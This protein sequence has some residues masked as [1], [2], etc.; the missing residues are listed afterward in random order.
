MIG[1]RE[2]FPFFFIKLLIVMLIYP[3]LS[4]GSYRSYFNMRESVF[5]DITPFPKWTGMIERYSAQLEMPDSKCGTVIYYPCTV[6][7][8]KK[9][10][11]NLQGESLHTKLKKVND[12]ANKYPYVIDQINWGIND[13]WETLYEFIDISGDC[14]DYAITK[15]YSLR[16]L[17]VPASRM[18]IMIV[19]DLNLGGIIHAVLGVYDDDNKLNVLD[20]QIKQ[21][22]SALKIYHYRP[23]YGINENNW[24][25]YQPNM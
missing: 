3:S 25:T 14:E 12:W 18:R 11:D 4:Y 16:A 2:L 9:L 19:Q 5:S 23:I 8:W 24:W 15:Y 21:V 1:N 10:I 6:K 22:V 13:Y 17:G 20:N 7:D